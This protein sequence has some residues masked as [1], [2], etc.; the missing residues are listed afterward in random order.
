M[1]AAASFHEDRTRS[2]VCREAKHTAA[3]FREGRTYSVV[4]IGP[5]IQLQAFLKAEHI[6]LPLNGQAYS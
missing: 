6:E 3:S 2:V 4:F 5:S 1:H